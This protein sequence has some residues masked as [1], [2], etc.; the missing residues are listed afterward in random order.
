MLNRADLYER[1]LRLEFK[2]TL[3]DPSRGLGLFENRVWRPGKRHF[4][5][6]GVGFDDMT[7]CGAFK[8]EGSKV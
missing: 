5:T 1:R 3:L 4:W 8:S 7:G 6:C 2:L